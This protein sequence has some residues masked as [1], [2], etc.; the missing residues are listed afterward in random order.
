MPLPYWSDKIMKFC[1]LFCKS[2]FCQKATS[3]ECNEI[4]GC[5]LHQGGKAWA[6]SLGPPTILAPI[7]LLVKLQQEASPWF[8]FPDLFLS[9]RK[10][11]LFVWD[12][13]QF[14]CKTTLSIAMGTFPGLTERDVDV[15]T[16]VGRGKRTRHADPE[17]YWGRGK[18]KGKGSDDIARVLA[19]CLAS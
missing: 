3:P 4:S 12:S 11:H 18:G 7:H 15:E 13:V 2:E 14:Q 6:L 5:Q 19:K 1:F 8:Y 17:V 9:P 10:P 16:D